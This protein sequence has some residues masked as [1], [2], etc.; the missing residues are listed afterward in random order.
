MTGPVFRHALREVRAAVAWSAFA[1]AAMALL[2][3]LIYP[4]YA[5][6][7]EGFELPAF[8][9]GLV[10]EGGSLASP[11][12]FLSSEFFS[13]IPPV[14]ASVALLWGTQA[15]AGGEGAGTLDLFMAQPV[16][17]R[18]MF[19]E[20]A[21]ALASAATVAVL[22]ALPALLVGA[23][24]VDM[25]IDTA[26]LAGAVALQVPL[27]LLFMLLGML[28]GAALPSRR[29]ANGVGLALLVGGWFLNTAGAAIETLDP[30]R[31]VSPFRWADA[32]EVLVHGMD[33]WRPAALL[34]TA[35]VLAAAGARAFAR[36]DIGGGRPRLA[37]RLRR[38]IRPARD[39]A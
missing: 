18:R 19:G 24:A 32:S 11:P 38:R 29:S 30:V 3:A 12:G 10:G 9:E 13:W 35:A 34:A 22:A 5:E 23:V 37:E 27:V 17:R 14:I 2:V 15:L 16:A 6:G 39:P 25:G 8:L 36:R 31:A 7:L 28:L 21:L 4:A 20:T 1:T 26:R 33:P